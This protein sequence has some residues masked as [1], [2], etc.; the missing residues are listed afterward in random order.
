M[1]KSTLG[2]FKAA[3]QHTGRNGYAVTASAYDRQ[4]KVLYYI[5]VPKAG[6]TEDATTITAI[7]AVSGA[8]VWQ[9]VSYGTK[10]SGLFV[11]KSYLILEPEHSIAM[12]DGDGTEETQPIPVF[13]AASGR[14]VKV[15]SVTDDGFVAGVSD[16]NLIIVDNTASGTPEMY[17][18]PL[19]GPR[20]VWNKRPECDGTPAAD[21]KVIVVACNSYIAGLSPADGSVVWRYRVPQGLDGTQSLHIKDGV[22]ELRSTAP[23]SVTFLNEQGKPIITSTLSSK[24]DGQSPVAFGVTGSNLVYVGQDSSDHLAVTQADLTTSQILKHYVLPSGI[25]LAGVEFGNFYYPAGIDF[26]KKSL[27]LPVSLPYGFIGSA[28]LALNLDDGSRTLNTT[29]PQVESGNES[30]QPAALSTLEETVN[31]STVLIAPASANADSLTAFYVTPPENEKTTQQAIALQGSPKKWPA[32]C[33]LITLADKKLLADHLGADY[34]SVQ[35]FVS[36]SPG[37]PEPSTC[38]YVPSAATA[39]SLT[40]QVEWDTDSAEAAQTVLAAN[41]DSFD[42]S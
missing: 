9:Q 5:S 28:L 27:Y 2:S 41:R 11:Y 4:L 34:H 29:P 19:A 17:A 35:K 18:I 16:G 6:S 36:I 25:R 37:L 1:G 3:W 23:S 12:I 39:D 22:I 30:S 15:W 20:E 14:S 40:V 13:D 33:S 21:D 7:S 10:F 8:T 32:A 31:Y 42:D 24:D 38:T 26:N